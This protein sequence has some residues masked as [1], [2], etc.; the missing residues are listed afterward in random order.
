MPGLF[1]RLIIVGAMAVMGLAG[2]GKDEGPAET[3]A[4]GAPGSAPAASEPVLAQAPVAEPAPAPEAGLPP[5]SAR[6]TF[7]AAGL[8]DSLIKDGCYSCHDVSGARIAP[9]LRA[10]AGLYRNNPQAL[11]TL[12]QKVLHG[13][14]GVWGPTPMI[15]HPQ[16]SADQVR[17]MI[18]AILKLN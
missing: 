13:G 3:G 7:V 6:V 4:I 10:V 17:P 1:G 18:E 8:P 15:A 11:D 14:G 2:C 12:T 9:P 16:L 5:Q